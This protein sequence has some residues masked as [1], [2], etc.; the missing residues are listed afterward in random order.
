MTKISVT[1]WTGLIV[2][3]LLYCQQGLKDMAGSL[4]GTIGALPT[5]F[6]G[7]LEGSEI[8]LRYKTFAYP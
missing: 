5:V 7:N 3:L 2:C 1:I 8:A 6:F 4:W